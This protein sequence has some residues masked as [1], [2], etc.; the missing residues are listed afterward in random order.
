MIWKQLES[1]IKLVIKRQNY[2][3][4]NICILLDKLILSKGRDR[5]TY[6][7]SKN[8]QIRFLY[9]KLEYTSNTRVVETSKLIDGININIEKGKE[10]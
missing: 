5:P 4:L 8:P 3:A 7:L 9:Q 1:I 10:K 6:L 2:F